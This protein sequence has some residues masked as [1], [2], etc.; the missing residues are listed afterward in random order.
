[1]NLEEGHRN[2][3]SRKVLADTFPASVEGM[4]LTSARLAIANDGGLHSLREGLLQRMRP[5]L[6][7][8]FHFLKKDWKK[9]GTSCFSFKYFENAHVAWKV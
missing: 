4:C 1:M 5:T 7:E 6:T 3:V 2:R 8:D 9:I